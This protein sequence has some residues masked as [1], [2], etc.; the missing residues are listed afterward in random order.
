MPE[1]PET[2]STGNF[3]P[4]PAIGLPAPRRVPPPTISNGLRLSRA[5]RTKSRIS[6]SLETLVMGRWGPSEARQMRMRQLGAMDMHMALL[7]TGRQSGK[8]LAGIE[9][10]AAIE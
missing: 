2:S 10:P 1:T 5:A 8:H 6:F 7:D 4:S 3:L 9:Q